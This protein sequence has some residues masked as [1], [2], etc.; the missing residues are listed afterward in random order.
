MSVFWQTPQQQS[1]SNQTYAFSCAGVG[2]SRRPCRARA[3]WLCDGVDSGLRRRWSAW[4]SNMARHR[5]CKVRFAMDV[6]S[7][8]KQPSHCRPSNDH[9]QWPVGDNM[10]LPSL[11]CGSGVLLSLPW[12]STSRASFL[13]PA[14]AEDGGTA[15]RDCYAHQTPAAGCRRVSRAPP[16]GAAASALVRPRRRCCKP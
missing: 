9:R 12:H 1:R 10:R 11:T 5:Q 14:Q 15:Q 7:S 3:H 8:R 16:G 6:G 13:W 2:C 4:P